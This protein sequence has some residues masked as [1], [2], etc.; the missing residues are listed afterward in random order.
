MTTKNP[1]IHLV[2]EKP[3]YDQIGSLASRNHLSLSSQVRDLLLGA[4]ET[5]EDGYLGK[6]AEQRSESYDTKKAVSH[7][8]FWKKALKNAR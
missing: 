1:R 6:V 5:Q 8:K 3:L 4:I 7:D 2:L